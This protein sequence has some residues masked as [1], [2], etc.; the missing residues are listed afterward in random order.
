[1][2]NEFVNFEELIR[3]VDTDKKVSGS[4]AASAHRY[5]IRFV[6]FDNF[7]DS[8]DFVSTMQEQFKCVVESV[9]NWMD[10]AY[11]DTMVTHSKLAAKIEEYIHHTLQ[12]DCVIAPFSEL[13]RFYDNIENFE[14]N[15]LIAT[16]KS[17]E[18]SK[19]AFKNKQRVY[20]PVIGLEGKISK[21]YNDTQAHIWYFKNTDKQLNY[22]LVLSNNSVYGVKGL[23]QKYTI[24]K[25]VQ[26]WLQIWR[27]KNAKQEII[28]T[29]PSIFA[30]AGFA[31]PDNAF[32]FCICH[33]V[34]E[35]LTD[36]L[37]LDFGTIAYTPQNEEHWLRLAKEIDINNFSFESF[38][39][40]Y[41]QIHDLADY[42]VF[43]KTWF[44]CKDEFEKWLLTSYYS[45]KFCE[46]G[47]ICEAI[48]N[49]KSYS[50]HEFFTSI[51]LTIFS[52]DDG[53]MELE[54]RNICL[55]QASLRNIKLSDATQDKLVEK[56]TK[57][58]VE[59][60]YITAI[61]YFSPLTNA[62]KAL[63]LKWLGE[64]KISK[65]EIK[66]FFPDLYYYLEKS[67]GTTSIQQK[68]A[69]DYIDT[70]KKAKIANQYTESIKALIQERNASV[71]TF[72]NWYQDFKTTKTILG[73]RDDIE[74]YYWIDGLGI[75]WIPFINKLIEDR[76][77][78]SIYLNDIYIARSKYPTT[79]QI[80]KQD[81][82]DLSN[83]VLSKKGD[84]DSIAHKQGNKYP[85]Y[86]IDEI[87]NVRNAIIDIVTEHSGKK[88]AIVSDH[89]LT[90]LSQFCDGMNLG[91]VESDHSGRIAIRTAGKPVSG[92]D[93]VL[94]ENEQTMC[95]LRHESLCSKVPIGQSSHG[96][97]TP[98][99]ILVP[100]FIIS[101]QVKTRNWIATL[102]DNEISGTNPIVKYSIKGVSETDI[103]YILY[104]GKRY[105]LNLLTDNLYESEHLN[106]IENVTE[107]R[108]CIGQEKQTSHLKMNLG[109]KEDD[110]FD[111]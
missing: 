51:A 111:I 31:R 40:N 35:F 91:G 5:P 110:L 84:I 63:A 50:N 1:M 67:F 44:E 86:I 97:C 62:E 37:K 8:F 10:K 49:C 78:D 72:N 55:Q 7:R 96:G 32:S 82:L 22:R 80:N 46:K 3:C 12:N 27:N 33:N 48:K 76:K 54:E 38:F 102:L 43:L 70:Y 13:A 60:G 65:E 108:L 92:N 28:S 109:A 52:F 95:A 74:V 21:F 4:N 15:A 19:E 17:I 61:R 58:S 107:I 69:L 81:L 87:D 16:I 11:C 73:G 94:L 34:Y 23:E 75:D 101:S 66:P 68:W 6:L 20:I 9:D 56:L 85:D 36:G 104:H 88:I 100:I 64:D 53:E 25:N 47:Y 26:E 90:A 71:I 79:T 105:E 98:E 45:N 99:E 103:P 29:S 57:L 14:F 42:N 2:Y 77:S 106:L 18:S 93:Y 89:G 59:K 24:V 39:N 41:F 83:N 30:N